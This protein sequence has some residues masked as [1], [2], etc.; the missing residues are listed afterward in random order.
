MLN[1]LRI[2][3]RS[4]L[5]EMD[6]TQLP[7][8]LESAEWQVRVAA[9]Q[10]LE[11]WGER[12]PLELLIRAL[13]DE[14][15]A[16]R[17]A[18]AHAVGILGS[19]EAIQPLVEALQDAT[20]LVRAT[21]V[22]ALGM[23]G[24]HA[25][26]EPLMLALN[27]EDEDVR[28]V[29]V[30]ASGK[31]GERVPLERLLAT[32]QD[33]A[34]QVREMA[35]L[36][37]GTRGGPIPR[38]ALTLALQDEDESVR[39]AAHF[40]QEMYPDRFAEMPTSVSANV[41]EE[42]VERAVD[43]FVQASLQHYPRK[44]ALRVLR[45]ALLVCWSIFLGYAVSITWNLVQLTRAGQA[46][47]TIRFVVQALSAPLTALAR[48]NIPAWV[49]GICM[50]LALLLLS[51]CL[52]ATRDTW[53]EYKWKHSQVVDD[54][55][56]E[57][58][59]EDHHQFTHAPGNPPQQIPIRS[60]LSRRTV[61]VGLTTVLI[62]GNGIAWSLLLNSK[63]GQGSLVT[64]LGRILYIYRKHTGSVRSVS[65]SPDGSRI[66]SGS[67]DKTVQVW[68]AANGAHSFTF[69]GL[70]STV[71]SVVWS[72]DGSR[73]ASGGTSDGTVQVWDTATGR[74]I[75]TFHAPSDSA[76]EALDWSPDGGRIVSAT[77]FGGSGQV[78]NTG[79]IFG[80][81]NPS[82]QVWDIANRGHSFSVD[83]PSTWG[84]SLAVVWSSDGKHISAVDNNGAI[85]VLDV[86]TRQ[87][88]FPFGPYGLSRGSAL[89]MYTE[90]AYSPD[91][92]HIAIASDNKMVEVRDI[93]SG[94]LVYT[95]RGHSSAPLGY[96]GALAWS[97]D[98]KRIASGSADKTVHVWD[99]FNGENVYI[100]Y[101]HADK[102]TTVAWSPDGKYIASG[103]DDKTVQVWDAG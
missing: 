40:L 87:S 22:Q 80:G 86:S 98:G 10:K 96:I 25:P 79:T 75:S 60:L 82:L 34:W 85:Q 32:L 23:L 68:E 71:L 56:L 74:N 14:H 44:G 4:L 78:S 48:F 5:S 95:Y 41:S 53:K 3:H 36:A 50:L 94:K 26:V 54:E 63:R 102:V 21:A 12:A 27:D 45:V 83:F 61:L 30:R 59:P 81:N 19:P 70:A 1:R 58:A 90:A 2:G 46:D 91:G 89:A 100:Y 77:S 49:P 35:V 84:D 65:W 69:S 43:P 76:V 42:R 33:S 24:E 73:I 31:M 29:A 9:V 13:K 39:R 16:V 88:T 18:A 64:G 20:W 72:P 6:E 7:A 28:A 55:E 51:G 52:W 17:A 62:I 57:I 47:L 92:K 66:A 97:P 103:S 93:S 99:A 67:D 37:L 101:G 11:K 38:S 15:E 8:A